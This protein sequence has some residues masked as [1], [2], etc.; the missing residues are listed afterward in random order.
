MAVSNAASAQSD[1]II[2]TAQRRDQN[3]ADVPIAVSVFTPQL[4]E[5]LQIKDAIAL[6]DIVPN[7]TGGNNTALGTANSYFLRGQGQDESIATADPAVGTYVDDIFVAR[8]NANNFNFFDVE[9][10]EVLRGPQG[11]LFGK[12]TSGGAIALTLRKPG[13]ELGGF[14]EVGIGA[15][16]R[17]QVRIAADI[18]I[19]ERVRSSF[20]FF[21]IEDDGWLINTETG[22]NQN[23]KEAF[24]FRAAFDIDLTDSINW[25]I[26]ADYID[27]SQT[28]LTGELQPNGDVTTNSLLENGL[29]FVLGDPSIES[30]ADPGNTTESFNLTSNLS[31]DLGAGTLSLI[32]GSRNLDQEFLVNFP[33]PDFSASDDIFII[34]N[35]GK[36]DQY[37]AELKYDTTLFDDK[38]DLT[39]G[40]FY[41]REENV[42][43][44]A[45]YFTPFLL[46]DRVL[47]NNADSF[48]AYGQGDYHITD[49]LTATVG[50]RFTHQVK[51][52]ALS[53]N[54]PLP[55]GAG[56][57]DGDQTD[58]TTENL[59]ALGID[60][61]LTDNIFTPRFALSYD[62]NDDLLVYASAT[63]GFRSGG[64]NSR[65]NTAQVSTP[66]ETE[67]IWS[68]ELGARAQ[69]GD[70]LSIFA[71]GF[72]TNLNDLQIT[73]ALADQPGIFVTT[74]TGELD[75]I[76]FELDVNYRPTENLRLFGSLGYQDPEFNPDASEFAICPEGGPNP[77]LGAFTDSCEVATPRRSPELTITAGAS[78]DYHI[79]G[80]GTISPRASLRHASG[81]HVA[82]SRNL[83][84]VDGFVLYNL[85]LDFAL[86][87]NAL[88]FSI[89]C[90][91][92]GNE[93]YEIA[94]FGSGDAY[95]NT[96]RR[97]EARLRYNFGGRR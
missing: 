71:T 43:D 3:V 46:R 63:R 52:F 23:D 47:T 45:A 54:N 94:T 35:V 88:T 37:S 12:N 11:T 48:A 56:G 93:R 24:G 22:N 61:E 31:V 50:L 95:F 34:D 92:C 68:Y 65:G 29:G 39:T 13:E 70:N 91:N 85:G 66:F 1:E 15:F 30:K 76:G 2:T 8:Q 25:Y 58:L 67:T 59:V 77:G 44:F 57:V 55:N 9:R 42:T 16:D 33:L 26:S 7:L 78:Y 83:V 32:L 62:V 96:P 4:L 40:L 79:D 75:N 36:H 86:E 6:V 64:W 18:P 49:R 14:A 73:S 87:S 53:D 51:D 84:P 82:G 74:N 19:S 81:D 21:A 38:L 5:D 90:S 60:T 80:F 17:R 27:D 72:L 20:N 10:L 97:W 69:I 28:N 41:L 89:E